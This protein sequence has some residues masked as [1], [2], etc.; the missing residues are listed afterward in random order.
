[1]TNNKF[2]LEKK[3]KDIKNLEVEIK[4]FQSGS[5]VDH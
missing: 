5:T 2:E 4:N 3:D 1:M